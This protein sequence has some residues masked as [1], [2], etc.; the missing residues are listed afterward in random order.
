MGNVKLYNLMLPDGNGHG[1]GYTSTGNQSLTKLFNR[2]IPIIFSFDTF[3]N[4][5][6]LA[7]LEL[8]LRQIVV[9]NMSGV[10]SVWINR[11]DNDIGTNP[12]D[13]ADHLAISN[14]TQ[15]A[16]NQLSCLNTALFVDYDTA[17]R[18]INLPTADIYNNFAV[19]GSLN[20]VLT[21]EGNPSTYRESHNKWLSRLY[22]RE[23]H[24]YGNCQF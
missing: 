2:S 19:W 3:A 18:P 12:N 23:V 11:P 5:Y 16:L 7:E 14:I 4:S 1:N 21:T 10:S 17:K 8:V 6:S 20:G 22:Y 15:S 9:S 13:H 24:G